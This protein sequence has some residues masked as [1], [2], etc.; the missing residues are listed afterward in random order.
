M[1]QAITCR[2]SILGA[3]Q[4]P[5]HIRS[6]PDELQQE[7]HTSKPHYGWLAKLLRYTG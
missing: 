2:K 1:V 6:V 5:I 4:F 7:P 3:V